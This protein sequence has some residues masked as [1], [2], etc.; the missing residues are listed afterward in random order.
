MGTSRIAK[1]GLGQL[2]AH[3]ADLIGRYSHNGAILAMKFEDITM[4][5][6]PEVPVRPP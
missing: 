1:N 6:A 4:P 5:I 2:R 3:Y